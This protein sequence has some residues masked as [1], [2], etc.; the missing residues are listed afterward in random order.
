MK[1][2]KGTITELPPNGIFVFGSNTQGRHG[3]GAA[4]IAKQKFGAIYGCNAGFQ[5]QS[6]A[7]IT[8][9]LTKS[10]HPSIDS[11][12]IIR[13]ISTLYDIAKQLP[14]NDFYIVYSIKPN[15]NSYTPQD[16]ANMFGIAAGKNKEI[17]S[18]I[19]FEKEFAELIKEHFKP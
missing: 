12:Y 15:L 5:G 1:T 19:I 9:D 4:L 13:Q 17:P 7:I 10:K 16:M 8:K 11:P 6:Y 18:N 3:K 2:Y 14:N